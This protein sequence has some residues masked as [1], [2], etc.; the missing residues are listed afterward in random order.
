M[1]LTVPLLEPLSRFAGRPFRCPPGLLKDSALEVKLA[2]ASPEHAEGTL[3]LLPFLKTTHESIYWARS[4]KTFEELYMHALNCICVSVLAAYL[5]SGCGESPEETQATAAVDSEIEPSFERMQEPE[6]DVV[7]PAIARDRLE[8]IPA[9]D[10]AER[11][12]DVIQT[13][14]DVRINYTHT[15]TP[16]K[17]HNYYR[18]I[19]RKNGWKQGRPRLLDDGGNAMALFKDGQMI[20]VVIGGLGEHSVRMLTAPQ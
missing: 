4:T 20:L 12:G 15:S 1:R 18:Q 8:A 11:V 6:V 19:L 17:V 14:K 10:K 9:F 7:D 13:A 3:G 16:I 2:E 5:F